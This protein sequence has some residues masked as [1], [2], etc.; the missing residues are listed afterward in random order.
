M[1]LSGQPEYDIWIVEVNYL[2]SQFGIWFF[3]AFNPLDPS[4]CVAIGIM[5]NHLDFKCHHWPHAD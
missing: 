2:H 1:R 3:V 4:K 5:Y